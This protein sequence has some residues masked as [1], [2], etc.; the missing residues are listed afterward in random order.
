MTDSVQN[1]GN[2]PC[3]VRK[4]LCS[5]FV[6][7]SV[8]TSSSG[9]KLNLSKF[10][11]G[12]RVTRSSK[13]CP[14]TFGSGTGKAGAVVSSN[15]ACN[16]KSLQGAI[17]RRRHAE[18]FSN[19][20]GRKAGSLDNASSTSDYGT[21]SEDSRNCS[22]GIDISPI[23]SERSR[24]IESLSGIES[25]ILVSDEDDAGGVDSA[26]KIIDLSTCGWE[27]DSSDVC[28]KD[29][30]DSLAEQEYFKHLRE[31]T[32][33]TLIRENQVTAI[34]PVLNRSGYKGNFGIHL[35]E[36]DRN[37]Y[38]NGLCCSMRVHHV[39]PVVSMEPHGIKFYESFPAML[40]IPLNIEPQ[41][42]AW[43]SCLYSNTSGGE[44]PVWERLPKTA[45][46]YRNG[47]LVITAQHFSLFTVILEEPYPEVL[48]HIRCRSGGRIWLN[49]VPGVKV[50]FPRG[51]LEQDIDA[52]VRVLY[53]S[54][55][56]FRRESSRRHDRSALAS[57]V[58]MLGPHGYKFNSAR[59]PV[60]ITLPIP[61]YDQIMRRFPGVQ[62]SV[63]QSSTQEGEPMMW[64]QLNVEISPAVPYTHGGCQLY[65]V[66]FPVHHFSFFKIVWDLLSTSLYEAKMG[67]SYF[68]P[69][70]SFSMMCQ[71]FME[72]NSGNSRFGLEVICYR[73]DR[74]LPEATNYR[75]R[76]GASLKPKM[77]RP[78]RIVIRLRSQMFEADV[79][80][81]E[82][83]DMS[84]EEPDFRGRDFEKQYACR[85]KPD[86]NVD[87][88]T[89][90]KVIVERIV[91]G[92]KDPLFEFNL[93]KTG[94]ETE[95]SLPMGHE[96]WTVLA[97]KELASSLQI[98]DGNNWKKFAQYIGF[99]KS[100]IKSKLQYSPDP[101]VAMMNLY[102]SRGGTPEEFTQALYAV[103]RDL[104]L[105]RGNASGSNSDR[106]RSSRSGGSASDS[107]AS[108]SQGSG[109]NSRS[110]LWGFRPWGRANN[111][112][113]ENDSE[114][115]DDSVRTQ[116]KDKKRSWPSSKKA[117]GG[118]SAK[119]RKYSDISETVTSSSDE[120]DGDHNKSVSTEK[121][122]RNQKKLSD[123]D[124]WKI[125]AKIASK[126]WRN[127]GRTLG[128]EEQVLQN[129]N[130]AHQSIGF[131]E[132]TYQMLLEWKG[133]KPRKC[134]FGELYTGL[135]N[136]GM[137]SV[138]K[139]LVK[140]MGQ[141]DDGQD[142]DSS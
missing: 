30:W 49:E 8:S 131:R 61:D 68:Y 119:R 40:V 46:S 85:F 141:V 132:C 136:E 84:K 104:R 35:L 52:Y 53:D 27:S 36:N 34:I 2:R 124:L 113:N 43:L 41:D 114:S 137:V 83:E 7:C 115:G 17:T 9:E 18:L 125:S 15:Y 87:R 130:H 100:E 32:E 120:S 88:G 1:S 112:E 5:E 110:L 139:H 47:C 29:D 66:S 133:R 86:V 90:G 38:R 140:L 138:A 26:A 109:G 72:E 69:Y 64:E 11:E 142:G 19:R 117:S 89:F 78:G 74:R 63:W 14:L 116:D 126:D 6:K 81:G 25:L 16:R 122:K 55:P 91:T 39:S 60:L 102:N 67:M 93:H 75:H 57:P 48:K 13:R 111:E 95:A 10:S 51:C 129:L 105:G 94:L 56:S 20:V 92:S 62:L 107:K 101:F 50:E 23:N 12:Q 54:E 73:S 58:I 4:S 108:S 106:S 65:L 70:I 121:H 103:S 118:S 71:A 82:D 127:L 24:D 123:R 98:T 76:V 45:Y 80:A 37:V 44:V 22:Y 42:E 96:R 79:E 21:L 134:T 77:V 99:T 59:P 33:V 31:S 135:T 97:M 128:I 28:G 3:R